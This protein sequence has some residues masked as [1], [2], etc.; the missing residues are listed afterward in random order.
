MIAKL[1]L[2]TFIVAAASLFQPQP[3]QCQRLPCPVGC[4]IP[5]SPCG[6]D[7]VC[8]CSIFQCGCVP[9]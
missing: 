6:G 1:V 4:M 9:Y 3:A 2:V 7:C 5:G 8:V